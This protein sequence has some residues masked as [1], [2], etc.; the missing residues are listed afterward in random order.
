MQTDGL[1]DGHGRTNGGL[2]GDFAKVPEKV[3]GCCGSQSC[4]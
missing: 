3:Y 2:Y 4:C 1:A